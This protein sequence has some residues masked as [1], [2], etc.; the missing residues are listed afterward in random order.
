M[1]YSFPLFTL[2]FFLGGALALLLA[3]LVWTR[4]QVPGAIPYILFMLAVAEWTFTRAL[5]AGG[6]DFGV[7]VFWGQMMWMG[8][9]FSGVFWLFFSLDYSGSSWWKQSRNI[10][11]I[12]IVPIISIVIIWTN[13]FHH[14][15]WTAISVS[16]Q[17]S[18]AILVWQHGFWF[19]I[20]IIFQYSLLTS[21]I[22]ILI[23]YALK[24][25]GIYRHQVTYILIGLMIPI[26]AN[27]L[28]LM[29]ITPVKGLDITPFTF[30]VA[31]IIYAYSIFK[32][33]FLDIV[34]VARNTLVENL[35]DGV[36]VLNKDGNLIDM[37]PAARHMLGLG[38]DRFLGKHLA[39]VCPNLDMIR[40]GIGS[41]GNTEM[42]SGVGDS[43]RY[44]DVSLV[45]LRDK[46]SFINGQ[47]IVLR[48]ITDRRKIEQ[49]L[50]ESEVR[51]EALVEQSNDGVLIVQDGI[52]KYANRTLAEMSGYSVEELIGKTMSFAIAEEDQQLI[53]DRYELRMKGKSVPDLYEL[54]VV[55]KDGEPRDVE[56]SIS[57]ITYEGHQAD[58]ITIRDLT[59][60]K[61][62]QRKLENLYKEEVKLRSNLQDEVIKRTKYTRAL[63]HELKTPLTSIL[64]SSEL[65]DTLLNGE[66]QFALV[67]NI[68]RASL[69]LEQRINELIE[70]AR[71]ETGMLKINPFPTDMVRIINEVVA[72]MSATASS[73]G[74]DIN[75]ELD[76]NLPLVQGD[77]GRLKQVMANL[78]SNAIK[79]TKSGRIE[80]KAEVYAREYLLVRVKDTGRGIRKE[81]ME[82]LFDPYLRKSPI[83][84]E[85][86]GLGIGLALCKIFIELHQG[87]IWAESTPGQGATFSFTIPLAKNDDENLV[88]N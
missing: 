24:H 75:S 88:I 28:F 23:N 39:I 47:L 65:L 34:P 37:N 61:L 59:D 81:E 55:R 70:L 66:T 11:F 52:Y 85:L 57:S 14:I 18:G 48:D 84:Q 15:F 54:K 9:I 26:A 79:Y 74:L 73:K 12:C 82:N 76:D 68:R 22:I 72:E 53:R 36:L 49:N 30:L 4:R 44:Y 5:E 1:E 29:G 2:A 3:G 67:K 35:P 25:P 20:A 40:S 10:F 31:G 41:E 32:L 87:K 45:P 21:G 19:W 17:S 56:I 43:T 80:I 6:I 13:Q 62:T 8:A 86:G 7:K 69:N 71:G 33:R 38:T 46:N 77:R 51:Y 78:L 60:R 63:V 83:G 42:K 58:M 64:A 27:I 50:R 16:P